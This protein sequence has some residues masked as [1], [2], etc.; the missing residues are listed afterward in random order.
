MNRLATSAHDE[1]PTSRAAMRAASPSAAEALSSPFSSLFEASLRNDRELQRLSD[2]V[3]EL[4][5]RLASADERARRSIARDLHDE[6]GAILTAANLAISRAEY[7]LPADAP[8]VCAEAL[9]QARECLAEAAKANHRVVERLH[10][11]ELEDGLAASLSRSIDTLRT[12][13]SLRIDL[14]YSVETAVPDAVALTL[15]RIAQEA[16]ANVARHAQATHAS[17]TITV[18]EHALTLLVED[19]GIGIS[20]A[21]RRKTGRFGLTGMRE[22]CE[23][24]GGTL[25]IASS[26]AGGTSVRARLPRTVMPR[27]VSRAVNG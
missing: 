14:S 25:Q 2:R 24:L 16:L 3:R 15:Y 6:T 11:P 18:D 21:A 1:R 20:P 13:S 23:A 10:E 26:K 8:A 27:S 4:G 19:D 17:V 7:F 12:V 5:A 9:R 22:R